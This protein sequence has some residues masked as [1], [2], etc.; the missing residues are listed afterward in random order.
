M[1]NIFNKKKKMTGGFSENKRMSKS[2]PS[3]IYRNYI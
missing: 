3:N 1:E 2:W